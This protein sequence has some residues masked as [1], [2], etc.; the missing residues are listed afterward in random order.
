MGQGTS[1]GHFLEQ[2]VQ[3]DETIEQK[4]WQ[5]SQMPMRPGA[6]METATDAVAKSTETA[7]G[8]N[9]GAGLST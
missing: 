8:A 3:Q 2:P 1:G 5:Q 6:L 9:E 7:G 4:H